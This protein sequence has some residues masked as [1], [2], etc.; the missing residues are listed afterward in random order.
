MEIWQPLPDAQKDIQS[1]T[2]CFGLWSCDPSFPFLPDSQFH[3]ELHS[4][5]M[6]IQDQH[7]SLASPD[8]SDFAYFRREGPF[9]PVDGT[10][11]L[12]RSDGRE[13]GIRK[14]VVEIDRCL[15][16]AHDDDCI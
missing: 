13:E 4:R 7:A 1:A 6:I 2:L 15:I 3:G 14:V 8:H 11:S 5:Y 16:D 10:G 9:A 12:G